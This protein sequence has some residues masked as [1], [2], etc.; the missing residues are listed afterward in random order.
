MY[1]TLLAPLAGIPLVLLLEGKAAKMTALVVSLIVFALSLLLYGAYAAAPPNAQGFNLYSYTGWMQSEGYDVGFALG[2]DG[3]SIFLLLL[4]TLM[5]PLIILNDWKREMPHARGYYVLLLLME[6]GVLGFFM[7]L[8]LLQFYVFFELVLIPAIFMIGIWGG[9]NRRHASLKFFL[10]T[11]AGSLLMLVAILYMGLNAGGGAFT[12]DYAALQQA[13]F[14]KEV[15][16]WLLGA[17]LIAFGIKAPIFPLHSWQAGAYAEA[18]TGAT[19][20]MAALLSK[21][22]VYGIL[23]VCLPLLPQAFDHIAPHM[24]ALAVLSIIYGAMAAFAQSDLKRLLAFSSLSHMGFIVLGIFANQA[25]ALSGAVL[26][27]VAHGISTAALFFLVGMLESR[28]GSREIDSYQGVAKRLPVFAFIFVFSVMAS[29]GLPG[30]SGFVGEFMIMLGAY[31]SSVIGKG[32]A[33]LAAT[34]VI[35]AGVYLLN[36]TRKTLFGEDNRPALADLKDLNRREYGLMLPLLV[37]MLLIGLYAT[38]FLLHI[39][40]AVQGLL[41]QPAAA[42]VPAP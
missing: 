28:T 11:L 12:T 31:S 9:K 34:G 16:L 15:Q 40:V 23:R 26:Q 24:A 18:P 5:F 36:M 14:S 3:I 33:I 42:V 1:L 13:G 7:A 32:F 29:V 10:Y 8:D 19:V 30:L 38:P 35:I 4:S 2:V 21:M 37:L 17:F 20:I 6:S 39:D 22:G 25:E 27:M 41:A